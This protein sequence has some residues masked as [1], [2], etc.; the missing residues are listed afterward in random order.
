M[1]IRTGISCLSMIAAL[2]GFVVARATTTAPAAVAPSGV[3]HER[4]RL[5]STMIDDS[6]RI[7]YIGRPAGWE[8]YELA[9]ND[10]GMKLTSDY[11]YVDRG[12]R[13]HTQLTLT[14]GKDYA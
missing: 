8:H 9:P 11:D 13:N 6:L 10:S 12:R 3:G 1:S 5:P 2:A 7:L 14:T 4:T